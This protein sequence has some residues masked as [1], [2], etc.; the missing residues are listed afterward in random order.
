MQQMQ[1]RNP[2]R[3]RRFWS[4]IQSKGFPVDA[5]PWRKVSPFLEDIKL[6]SRDEDGSSGVN[7]IDGGG[8]DERWLGASGCCS[9]VAYVRGEKLGVCVGW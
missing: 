9:A 7:G 5:V 1:A 4:G 3:F 2:T 8:G 6:G